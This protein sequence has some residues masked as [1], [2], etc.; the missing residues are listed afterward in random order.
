MHVNEWRPAS[1][2]SLGALRHYM[3]GSTPLSDAEWATIGAHWEEREIQPG[4]LLLR[5]GETCHHL[6]FLGRGL[7]RF[8]FWKDGEDKTKFFTPENQLFTSQFS[9][10]NEVPCRENIE[11]IEACT[12]LGI[13]RKQVQK[14]Y[15][16]SAAWG[17]FIRKTIQ[18]VNV[19][20]EELLEDALH[21]TAAQRYHRLLT[22]DPWMVQRIPLRH[23]AS[24]LG[25]APESLSRIRKKLAAGQNLT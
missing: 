20:T 19:W 18:Q 12:V 2:A 7:L 9:F 11:A 23:L 1:P 14:L 3:A 10:S 8:F 22:E 5:E 13:H 6:Y 25:I 16:E 21:Q 15:T 24:Y 4:E 17:A